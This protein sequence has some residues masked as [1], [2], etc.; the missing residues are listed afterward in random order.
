MLGE[1]D[2]RLDDEILHHIRERAD[3]LTSLGWDPDAALDEA[4]RRFGNVDRL[5]REL[6]GIGRW[7]RML[8]RLRRGL[9]GLASDIRYAVR[10]V[11]ARPGFA[12]SITVTLALGIG[13]V[14]SIFAVADALLIRP[15]RYDAA[16]RWV[17]VSQV[18]DEGRDLGGLPPERL[19]T[20]RAEGTAFATDW[21]AYLWTALARSDGERAQTLDVLAVTPEA[22]GLLGVP[23]VRGR[24]FAE[25]DGRS[26][27]P[28]VGLLTERYWTTLGADPGVVGSTITLEGLPVTV[29]GV[30]EE[31]WKFPPDGRQIDVWVPIRDDLTYLDREATW[32]A[33]TW[34]RMSAGLSP[35]TAAE[36]AERLSEA[37][38]ADRSEPNAWGIGLTP[39]G[40]DRAQ[41]EVRQALRVLAGTGIALFLIS[42]VNALNLLVVR[43]AARARELAVRLAM[44]ASRRQ[45]TRQLL[46]E[47]M[48]LGLLAGA[49][50]V[51]VA[52]LAVGAV[53][54]ILP[55]TVA[56]SSP[57]AVSVEDRTLVFAFLFALATGMALGLLPAGWVLRRAAG[58]GSLTGR[59]GD[60]L[61]THRRM[62][63]GLVVAQV[64]LSMGLLAVA[65]VLTRGV[66]LLLAVDPGFRTEQLVLADLQPSPIRYPADADRADFVH[67][68]EAALEAHPEIQGVALSTIR[69]SSREPLQAEG[70]EQPMG[71]PERVPHAAVSPDY[72]ETTGLTLLEGRAF[73][74]GDVGTDAAIVD[75]DM[76]R[77][78]WGDGTALGRRFRLGDGDWMTV[79]GVVEEL[80]L[81]GRDE[82]SGPHQ[83]LRPRDPASSASYVE[84]AIRSARSPDAAVAAFQRTLH[85]LDPEQAY[86][87]ARSASAWLGVAEEEPRFVAT[88][89]GLL[90]SVAVVLAAVGLFGLLSYSVAQRRREMSVRLALG[91]RPSGLTGMVVREGLTVAVLGLALGLCLAMASVRIV[92]GLVYGVAPRDP[93]ALALASAVLAAVS[94]AASL[95]PARRATRADP[96]EVLREA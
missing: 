47:G 10:G 4:R 89:M 61:P 33:G 8:L 30:L 60:G 27:A 64:A 18:D 95:I 77:L 19:E 69:R 37:L 84:L 41:P 86:Y 14:T 28:A 6:Q 39:I 17:R 68:L 79:V 94:V 66:V 88:L 72:L 80:M 54:A 53:A 58:H 25:E 49:A 46:A 40:A 21:I 70:R 9:R 93:V 2:D 11:V 13:A 20:W 57:H 48:V 34:A 55:E 12:A 5:R 82:R 85:D 91:A 87:R 36:R 67:R 51:L 92:E 76:A 3:H 23:L 35:T 44:G 63:T 38:A 43:T 71:S 1:P 81:L 42:L 32:Y 31:G 56:Y 29:V 74:T 24:A 45:L 75:R 52:L 96:A 83:F 22:P 62:R 50:A 59:P 90:G 26:G 65:S 15:L 73:T 78:L 7:E 16:E